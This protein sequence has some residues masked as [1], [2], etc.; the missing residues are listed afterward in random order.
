[1]KSKA[2]T[3]SNLSVRDWS[4]T[5]ERDSQ[6]DVCKLIFEGMMTVFIVLVFL[7]IAQNWVL[8]NIDETPY[9]PTCNLAEGRVGL[10]GLDH[11]ETNKTIEGYNLILQ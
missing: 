6:S 2:K 4:G 8:T 5:D 9:S 1:M 11:N 10:G 3:N 7:Y